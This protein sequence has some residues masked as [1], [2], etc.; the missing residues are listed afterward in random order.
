MYKYEKISQTLRKKIMNHELQPG[1]MLPDQN[2][3]AKEFNT[4]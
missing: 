3:L 4:T 1:V 2:Q